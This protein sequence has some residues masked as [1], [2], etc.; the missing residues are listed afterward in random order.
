M[1]A[2]G[3]LAA[4]IGHLGTA[5]LGSVSIGT[6]AV[7]FC[8]FLYSFLLFLTT[9][10]IAAAVVK[11]DDEMVGSGYGQRVDLACTACGNRM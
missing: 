1:P 6:L 9:P 3:L 7:S 4:L 2:P 5:Q 10:D 11:K 8:T